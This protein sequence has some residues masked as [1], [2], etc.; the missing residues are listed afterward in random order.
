M[1]APSGEGSVRRV[2]LPAIARLAGSRRAA[3]ALGIVVCVA[4]VTL[5]ALR[6]AAASHAVS[7]AP[8]GA[9]VGHEAPDFTLAPWNAAPAGQSVRLAALKGHPVVVNF[10]AT[11][12]EPCQQEAPLLTAAWQRYHGSGVLFLG[13]ALD[14]QPQDGAQFLRRYGLTYPCGPE[15]TGTIATTYALVGLPATIFIGRDGIVASRIDGQLTGAA[16][17]RA[18]Q[19]LLR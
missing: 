9:L 18:I 4:L 15:G 13:V 19:A 7:S 2:W 3:I 12:C 8:R 17:D 11:W 14:T 5:L 10:W 6:F 16:L 1:A